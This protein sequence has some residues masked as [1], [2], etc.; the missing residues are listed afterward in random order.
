M[1]PSVAWAGEEFDLLPEK[2]AYWRGRGALLIADPH[3]G[4]AAHFR[5]AGIPVP[6]G[7]TSAG[8]R[9]IDAL[10]AKT[11][12][13]ELII[14]GDL[15]HAKPGVTGELI[16]ALQAWRDAKASLKVTLI[17]G[18]HDR[19]AGAPPEC[20]RFDCVGEALDVGDIALRHHPDLVEGKF[21]IGG[22]VHPC[23]RLHSAMGQGLRLPC[24]HF[25]KNV[26]TLPAFG[27]FTGTHP[28]RPRVGDR[29]FAVGP[30]AVVE[31]TPSPRAGA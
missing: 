7:T 3:F 10:L 8:L 29:V 4:K 9:R 25:G 19:R 16:D 22:H 14:L 23:V 13:A 2:A 11:Q 24:F 27:D 6:N 20:L 5:A 18:N 31:V 28:V 15:F 30:D 26:A 21:V 1:P 17:S 12:A